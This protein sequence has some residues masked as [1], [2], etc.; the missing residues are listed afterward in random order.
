MYTPID[1][2]ISAFPEKAI[3]ESSDMI[4]EFTFSLKLKMWV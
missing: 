2:M 1:I 4:I 3:G